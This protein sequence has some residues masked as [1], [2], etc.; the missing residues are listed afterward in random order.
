MRRAS[1]FPLP[2]IFVVI[3]G[4]LS[5]LAACNWQNAPA[6]MPTVTEE[7]TVMG[8]AE[9]GT[10]TPMAMDTVSVTVLDT[11]AIEFEPTETPTPTVLDTAT[12]TPT[13]TDQSTATPTPTSTR[14]RY[15]T[16]TRPPT[17][18]RRPTKTP[19][20]TLTP[21]PPYADV[22][23]DQPGSLS[24]VTSPFYMEAGAILGDNAKIQIDLIDEYGQFLYQK[25]LTYSGYAGAR[26]YFS[27]QIPFQIGGVAESAR[28]VV[29]THDNFGRLQAVRAV[30]LILIQMGDNV[31]TAGT[32]AREPYL[33]RQPKA[34][35]TVSGG[36]LHLVGLADPV[37]AT[38]LVIELTDEQ[39]T[40]VGSATV[41]VPPPSGD[42][43]H[44]PFA[45]DIPY[46][47]NS[48]TPVRLNI[49]Q[50]SD[51]RLPGI[52]ALTSETV[53]LNP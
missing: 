21:T 15:V 18:T 50:N 16:A 53:V 40:V 32:E 35:A 5:L 37:N 47:V 14:K 36:V 20:I 1:G 17:A 23:I 4:V 25:T 41:T 31:I 3:I 28:M 6:S 52:M 11:E 10:L 45:V 8:A 43:S 19:T 44:T 48:S 46:S 30:D 42:L 29:S 12:V 24:K 22:S 7:V 51:G 38:P 33:I 26:V 9:T 49:H 27:Q 34:N 13:S 2:I 39:G